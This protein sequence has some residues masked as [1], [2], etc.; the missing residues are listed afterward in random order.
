MIE[1]DMFN[2]VPMDPFNFVPMDPFY[3]FSVDEATKNQLR[4]SKAWPVV[5]AIHHEAQQYAWHVI[6][7]RPTLTYVTFC[8]SLGML[9][10]RLKFD[11]GDGQIVIEQYEHCDSTELT[12]LMDTTN[13][14]Y[15]LKRIRELV[16]AKEEGELMISKARG[17]TTIKAAAAAAFRLYW[18]EIAPDNS[19]VRPAPNFTTATDRAL[20]DLYM[21]NITTNDMGEAVQEN[22]HRQIKNLMES[23]VANNIYREKI[24]NILSGDKFLIRYRRSGG[25]PRNKELPF[26]LGGVRF[27]DIDEACINAY[28]NRDYPS[29]TAPDI[30]FTYPFRMYKN[31][32]GLC[33]SVRDL[34]ISTLTLSNTSR[35][36]DVLY[37]DTKDI[38]PS[39]PVGKHIIPFDEGMTVAWS[40][41]YDAS[42]DVWLLIPDKRGLLSAAT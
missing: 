18:T 29:T 9:G 25:D 2:F 32:D 12:E 13:V 6:K 3:P 7:P 39:I 40:R 4:A 22:L 26:T 15:A 23:T 19:R 14:K 21:G 35:K 11:E 31:F 17:Y 28:M 24:K 27:K 34:I 36:A 42:R 1:G 30:E 10:L 33:D 38:L 8:D 20:L 41:T 16:K 37:N 5:M